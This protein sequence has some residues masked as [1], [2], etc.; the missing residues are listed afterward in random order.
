[1]SLLPANVERFGP[2]HRALADAKLRQAIIYHAEAHQL[3]EDDL[4][5]STFVVTSHWLRGDE[6]N[7][8]MIQLEGMDGPTHVVRGLLSVG[9]ELAVGEPINDE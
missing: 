6:T 8:Y 4:L 7:R 1:M 5:L 9:I 2:E 3:D